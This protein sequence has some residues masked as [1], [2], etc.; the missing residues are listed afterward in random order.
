MVIQTQCINKQGSFLMS[1]LCF[2]LYICQWT[3]L[4]TCIY[5]VL[6]HL[7]NSLIIEPIS[8]TTVVPS[9]L[10]TPTVTGR[11]TDRSSSNQLYYYC[12]LISLLYLVHD[13]VIAGIIISIIILL[14]IIT[15]VI[16][17]IV[18]ILIYKGEYYIVMSCT[19][20]TV[21]VCP[22]SISY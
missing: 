20:I 14:I 16:L 9:F 12:C 7:P 18:I 6:Y 19:V 17:V 22:T 15:I 1:V 5:R 21:C 13:G 8:I 2:I 11:T 3:S 10:T 4:H